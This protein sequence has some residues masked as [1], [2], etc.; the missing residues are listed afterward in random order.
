MPRLAA[1]EIPGVQPLVT[2]QIT[3]SRAGMMVTGVSAIKNSAGIKSK[4]AFKPPFTVQATVEGLVA[5]ANPFALYLITAA[6]NQHLGFQ[7]T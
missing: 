7:E 6:D 4:Q 5:H 2:P 1:A 3:F